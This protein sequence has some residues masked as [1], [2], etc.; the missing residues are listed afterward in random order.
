[1]KIGI[2]AVNLFHRETP[3][4]RAA[5]PPA[6]RRLGP[7][8]D[9]GC[10]GFTLLE[11]L[12]GIMVLLTMAALITPNLATQMVE[13]RVERSSAR[14]RELAAAMERFEV[15]VKDYPGTL[16]QLVDPIDVEDRTS[17]GRTFSNGHVAKWNGPYLSRMVPPAGI[18]VGIGTAQDALVRAPVFPAAESSGNPWWM[19]EKDDDWW[20]A[21]EDKETPEEKKAKKETAKQKWKTRGE[22]TG[23]G[24]SA[25]VLQIAVLGVDEEDARSLDRMEDGADGL[26]GGFV[27]WTAA[28]ANGL[29]TL[30]FAVPVRGC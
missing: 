11:V 10:G 14:L 28:D 17:C 19:K 20:D 25:P 16:S 8:P 2:M 13:A 12:I 5:A 15:D 22:T 26:D 1:M 30:F 9:R 21:K 29:V 4:T 7:A 23:P 6:G 3:A 24:Q 18:P 27:R